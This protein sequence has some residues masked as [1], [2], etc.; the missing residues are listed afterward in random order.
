MRRV[1]GVIACAVVVRLVLPSQLA[2]QGG[3]IWG[4]VADTTG[5]LLA[6]ATVS[7]EA[8]GGRTT[9]NDQGNYEIRR[10]PAGT[11]TV[12]VRLLG[13]VAQT[14]RIAVSEEQTVRQDFS[15][16]R[17][18]IGLAPVDLVVGSRA[19]HTGAE[20][21]A[22]PVD[23][24]AAE[25]LAQQG[26]SETSQILQALAASVNFPR[27]SVTDANDIVR[28]FTLRGLS[29]DHTLV[30]LNGW[31]RHQTPLVNNFA[32]GMAA[33][34]SG[35]DLN[36]IPVSA[37][38]RIE[39]LRDG[40][41]AQYGSDAIAG[42]VNI[43]TK[44]GQFTPVVNVDDGRYV[45]DDYPDDGT[46]VDVN[47]GWGI[48]L[49]RGSLALFGEFLDRQPTNRAWA[50]P[51]ETSV[52]GLPD[53]IDN[54]GRVVVKRNP[55]P[56]PNHHWGDGLEKDI[57]TLA[58]L[59]LP[60]NA[61]GTSE[62]Y[63]F[64]GYSFREGTGNSFR[65]YGTDSRNWPALYPLGFLPEFAPHVTDYSAAGGWRGMTGG[66][67]ADVGASLGHNHFDYDLRNTLNVS[68]GPCL[69]PAAPCAPAG[70]PNQ[71]SFFAGRL[72][73][74]EFIAAA[75]VAKSLNVG[76][77]APIHLAVGAAFRR[78]R[79][80]IVQGEP[81]SYIDGGDT[82][83]FGGRAVA[84]S[85]GFP[86]FTPSDA[87]DHH[88]TN[89]AVYTDA[90]TE[91]SQ[92]LLANVAGRFETYSD[93]GE[94][95]TG[96]L[97]LRYQPWKRLA[98]RGTA[99]T[100][101]RAPGLSQEYFSKVVTNVVGG[102]PAQTGIFPVGDA[103][104]RVLGS[105]P[106]RAETAVNFSGGFA[107]SPWSN[108]TMTAD[109]FYIK[110]DSRVLLGATFD[111]DTTLAILKRNG[112]TDVSGIQYFTNGLDTRTQGVD[113]T[114]DLRLPVGRAGT[115]HLTGALNYTKNEIAR[116]NPLPAVL[117]NSPES[118]LL[119]VVTRVA[120]EEEQ[121]D[122]RSTATAQYS[123]GRFHALARGSYFG[124]F[125]SA[126]PG[127]CD[128]CTET[129][130][131]KSLV[132]AELGYRFNHVDLSVGVRNLFDTYPDQPTNDFNNNFLTFPWAA[133]SPFGYNGRYLYSRASVELTQ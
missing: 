90:E 79:Y 55:A 62:I 86:G 83:Q 99:S 82:T 10:V 75:N 35:V 30:L 63:A 1:A 100:G 128:A 7:V 8:T 120:I 11:H 52:T 111:D 92:K 106:L 103:V 12:R 81:A 127:F 95:V 114:A 15:L 78:E 88:R 19:R 20:E 80:Q 57:M 89:F 107:Y 60:L 25:A 23:V 74:E 87:S 112:I 33:G 69:D 21:L 129:Y 85:Q 65:R 59:R 108:V 53:S 98:L 31:R 26:T 2:A 101:F 104:A 67:A 6:R 64:G 122:W 24:Y 96:K 130:G 93:V 76:L 9:S 50:D 94:R 133:A 41:S 131:G 16:R 77:P 71:T 3:I 110:I 45:T 118:R 37:I 125:A 17:Q 109:Y 58:N 56:Q 73:R 40:A 18:P 117:Q 97:A 29:P 51:F 105:K 48:G 54:Q 36:A 121:P 113:V 70:I 49:G 46:T 5:A 28:P 47:G 32:Y 91:L 102:V 116:V 42:V 84:G 124:G 34:S 27:Q 132:D 22:V 115:L 123:T 43:V 14:V 61:A 126:K 68:L 39:V 66:W 72:V 38:D 13:Y 4:R 44:E 119:D